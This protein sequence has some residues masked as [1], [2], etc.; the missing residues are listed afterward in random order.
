MF[1]K[2]VVKLIPSSDK[3]EL[4]DLKEVI[5]TFGKEVVTLLKKNPTDLKPYI[6]NMKFIKELQ[7][8]DSQIDMFRNSLLDDKLLSKFDELYSIASKQGTIPSTQATYKDGTADYIK[9]ETVALVAQL[10]ANA[11]LQTIIEHYN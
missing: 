5:G 9:N 1:D 7:L 11:Q 10:N 6:R 2:D 4:H 8:S 3:T